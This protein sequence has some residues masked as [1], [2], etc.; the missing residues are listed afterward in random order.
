MI[1]EKYYQHIMKNGLEYGKIMT[2]YLILE[3][4]NLNINDALKNKIKNNIAQ[5]SNF[6]VP[7]SDFNQLLNALENRVE[8]LLKHPDFNPFKEKLREQFPEQYGSHPFNFKGTTYYL[9]NKGR[10][11][12]I[13]SLIVGALGFKELIEEHLKANR[14]LKYIYKT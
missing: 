12:Y 2:N 14:P 7:I 11:F 4:D 6:E 3:Y 10:E 8:K 5:N 13:D 1:K 9:Y